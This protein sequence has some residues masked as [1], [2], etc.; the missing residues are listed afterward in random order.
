MKRYLV[1]LAI[2]AVL[3]M[4]G[5]YVSRAVRFRPPPLPVPTARPEVALDITIRPDHR[6][7]P[8]IASVPKDHIVRLTV[9][10]RS[11]GS[12]SLSLMGYQDRLR[13]A[14]IAPDSLWRGEFVADRPGEDFAW[15]LEG[16]P[17]GRLAVL[18]SHLV[19]G[20]K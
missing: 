2:A 1:L 4:V 11:A 18:G 7:L 15:V 17:V 14:T 3:G 5:L 20:H 10:N 13:V 8:G 16:Q 12:A 6:I 9:T 19:D